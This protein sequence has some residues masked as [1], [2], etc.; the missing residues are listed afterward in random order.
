MPL[1]CIQKKR[2]ILVKLCF[3]ITGKE[4]LTKQPVD[5]EKKATEPNLI[6]SSSDIHTLEKDSNEI[7]LSTQT[8]DT[9]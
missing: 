3:Y 5:E 8:C 6:F 2:E 1:I 4:S 7:T 9:T